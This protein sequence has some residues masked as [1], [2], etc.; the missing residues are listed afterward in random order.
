MWECIKS[1]LEQNYPDVLVIMIDDGSRSAEVFDQIKKDFEH[2][3]NFFPIRKYR[4]E[5]KRKAQK[6]AFDVLDERVEI[7]VTIDS[8]TVLSKDG[9][10]NIVQ[11]FKNPNIGAITGN[12]RAIKEENLLTKLIDGRYFSAF[13]QERAAQSLFGTVLCCSGPFAAYRSCIIREVKECYITQRFLVQECTYGDDRHLTNLVLNEGYQV[14]YEIKAHAVTRVPHIYKEFFSQQVRWNKSFYRELL[15]TLKFYIRAPQN[16]HPYILYDLT[17]QTMLLFLLMLVI[18]FSFFRGITVSPIYL[19]QY[20]V[21]VFG[22]S[23]LRA[24]YSFLRSR[25]NNLLLFPIYSFLHIFMLIPARI[26]AILTLKKAGWG[27]R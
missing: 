12:V 4:N 21:M 10:I 11:K 5:G 6:T 26:Y 19:L 9:L 22:I 18:S 8:D 15:W 17:I 2:Y 14:K 23:V 27:T 13:N 20:I 25:D 16:F 1:T 3:D 24:S 7:I